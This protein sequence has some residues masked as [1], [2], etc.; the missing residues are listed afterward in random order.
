LGA[1]QT[2]LLFKKSKAKN[3]NWLRPMIK[4]ASDKK[5]RGADIRLPLN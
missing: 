3:F 2:S 1:A 4:G 5:Q